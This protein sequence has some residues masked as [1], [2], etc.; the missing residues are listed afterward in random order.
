VFELENR[1]GEEVIHLQGEEK[2]G[3]YPVPDYLGCCDCG[4]VHWVKFRVVDGRVEMQAGRERVL[5]DE[6]RA[7]VKFVCSI[8]KEK[9]N[10]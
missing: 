1:G 8:K 4:L 2:D 6:A 7:K 5:T 10:E 9:V 3:W